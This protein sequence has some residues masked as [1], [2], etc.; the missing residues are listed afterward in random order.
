MLL[1]LKRVQAERRVWHCYLWLALNMGLGFII[2]YV[3][4][5]KSIWN[6]SDEASESLFVWALNRKG[7]VNVLG[8]M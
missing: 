7:F 1:I 4:S 2:T 3:V 8:A 5:L 6:G